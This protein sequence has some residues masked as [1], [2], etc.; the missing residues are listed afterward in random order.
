[1]KTIEETR[2]DCR[3]MT[4]R[5]MRYKKP[6]LLSLEYE[7]IRSELYDIYTECGEEDWALSDDEMEIIIDALGG[8]EEEARG[9]R[10]MFCDLAA[11]CEKL[12]GEL[13]DWY[14]EAPKY[15]N[16]FFV[17]CV[18]NK[19]SSYGY[20]MGGFDTYEEDYFSLMSYDIE[21]A[22]TEA[23][24]RLMSLTKAELIAKAGQCIGIALAFL[25]IRYQFDY[26]KS[27]VDI[28]KEE[29]VATMKAMQEINKIY[30]KAESDCFGYRSE[31]TKILDSYI[32]MLP[33]EV[34]VA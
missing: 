32:N 21:I 15:F 20:D 14:S 27:T 33:D 2:E 34:W 16:D 25:D 9:V 22:Q 19:L 26:L 18:G 30:D 1:M 5:N 10:L 6:A 29:S 3:R 23:G 31:S 28:L 17:G 8:D 12:T 7:H 4:A 11:K 13:N 24:K